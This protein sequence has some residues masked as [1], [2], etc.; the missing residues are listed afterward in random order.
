MEHERE[1]RWLHPQEEGGA[2]FASLAWRDV[3]FHWLTGVSL[4]LQGRPALML[5][6]KGPACLIGPKTFHLAS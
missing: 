1:K 4:H 3:C 6:D 2:V 5:R